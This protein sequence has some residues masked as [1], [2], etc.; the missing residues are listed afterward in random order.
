[1]TTKIHRHHSPISGFIFHLHPKKVAA[2][3]I[4]FTLSFGLGGM[5]ATLFVVL[6]A[7]G[8]LQLLSYSADSTTAYQSILLMY[9]DSSPAG[10]IRNI[11]H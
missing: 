11:H 9:A 5:A 7:T 2:E 6:T 10:F 8:V 3:T 4:R 1:M